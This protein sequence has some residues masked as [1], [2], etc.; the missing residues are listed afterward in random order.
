MAASRPNSSDDDEVPLTGGRVT[1]G[2]VRVGDTVRR[3]PSAN[4]VL[5]RR[6]LSHLADQGFSG[7]P[8]WLGVDANG[9]EIFAYVEG[10]VPAELGFHEDAVLVA[11]AR[12][13]RRFHDLGAG[14]APEGT[15]ICHNDLSPC[16]FVFR[17]GVPVAII[18]FDAAAAGPRARDV[19]YAA[20]L[21]LDIGGDV[22]AAEHARRLALFVGARRCRWRR[23]SR[24]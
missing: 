24:R 13:I 23:S 15:V 3:P 6:L 11:A 17:D 14:I 8:A 9:R 4:A 22:S 18:D 20:W 19:G 21:W 12:L 7:V 1:P 5:V 16:N 10:A 2:V